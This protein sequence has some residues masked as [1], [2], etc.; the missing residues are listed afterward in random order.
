MTVV[1]R[2][3][4]K[5]AVCFSALIAGLFAVAGPAHAEEAIR[6]DYLCKGRFDATAVT[7]FFFNQSPS[8]VVLVMGEGARRLPQAMS[9]S[10]ARYASGTETFWIKGDS[11]TWQLGKA[12]AS[13]CNVKPPAR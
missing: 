8:E 5:E 13:S 3:K 9:A 2:G 10:G 12:P 6:A 7:A 1:E 4:A 11:A